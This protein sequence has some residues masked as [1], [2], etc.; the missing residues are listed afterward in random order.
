MNQDSFPKRQVQPLQGGGGG[1][2]QRSWRSKPTYRRMHIYS[3]HILTAAVMYVA[4]IL[5]PPISAG[6]NST[7]K[8]MLFSWNIFK[9]ASEVA[10]AIEEE[11]KV[12]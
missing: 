6:W 5:P 3:T 12:V 11:L 4:G 9:G 10:P 8:K 7:G 2:F 1:V